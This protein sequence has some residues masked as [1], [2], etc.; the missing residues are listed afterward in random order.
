MQTKQKV[1]IVTGANSGMGLATVVALARHGI[2][3]IMACRSRKRG[4]AALQD[5]V[6]Q[7]GS[8]DIELMIC[9]L[10]SA[11][12][13]REFTRAFLAR[14]EQLDGLIHNAGVFPIRRETTADGFELGIGVNHL[15]HFLLAHLL[16]DAL[17]RA[18]Q[19]RVVVV[20]SNAYKAGHIHWSDPHLTKGYVFWRSY[21][22]SKLANILFTKELARRLKETRVTANCLHPGAV[23]TQIGVNRNTGFGRRILAMMKPFFLTPEKGAETAVYLATSD[24]VMSTSGE[25][26]YRK[27]PVRLTAKAADPEAAKRLWA[28]SER[29]LGL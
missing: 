7:S 24:K 11:A 3:V 20:S 8:Q 26:Y 19:G 29:E 6:R 28:W 15:G 4:E 16:L 18:P 25:Y 12:G 1:M 13:I 22:Q 5:A 23:A 9:D 27:K 17:A 21:A 14:Y 10:G 2:R